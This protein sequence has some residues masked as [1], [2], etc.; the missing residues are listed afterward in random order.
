VRALYVLQK[1]K[2][3]RQRLF[4]AVAA[5][6]LVLAIY[7][8]LSYYPQVNGD[9]RTTANMNDESGF[10]VAVG[11]VWGTQNIPFRVASTEWVPLF[12]VISDFKVENANKFEGGYGSG[13]DV[14]FRFSGKWIDV[15]TKAAV[16]AFSPPATP[17][18]PNVYILH[19]DLTLELTN[20]T[21][22][23]QEQLNTLPY[24]LRGKKDFADIQEFLQSQLR[25]K[26]GEQAAP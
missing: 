8:R 25:I 21:V 7:G 11:R 10:Y 22:R 20:L 6:L 2:I 1:M 9:W 17:D 23:K 12:F 14:G 16:P 13:S 24:M 3:T 5:A 19:K 26:E 15:P 18:R 4:I